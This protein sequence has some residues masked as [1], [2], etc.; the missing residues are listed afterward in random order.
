MTDTA[1]SQPDDRPLM[2]SGGLISPSGP[3]PDYRKTTWY[4]CPEPDCGYRERARSDGS[5]V[6]EF[7]PRHGALLALVAPDG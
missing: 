7:C 1:G 2:R 3:L 6:A 5:L 4:A